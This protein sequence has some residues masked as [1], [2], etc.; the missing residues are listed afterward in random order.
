[1]R[2]TS[3]WEGFLTGV[4]GGVAG[5]LAMR[6]YWQQ[7]APEI[8]HQFGPETG[9]PDAGAYPRFLKLD[10]PYYFGGRRYRDG[11]SSTA[12]MGRLLYKAVTGSEPQAEETKELLS[13]LV[14]WGYGMLQGGLYGMRR[15]KASLP[16]LGGGLNHG[17]RLWL[18]GDEMIGPMLGLQ[19]GPT[20]IP[21][22]Q[23]VNRLGAHLFYGWATAVVTKV[24]QLI[25]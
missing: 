20:A 17:V 8:R 15:R 9:G 11:E 18:L 1:M 2:A 24:L 25:F 5:L 22:V 12:V 6:Y 7:V 21:P 13:Y 4:A 10:R 16:D 3:R 14:H 23:H 19:S